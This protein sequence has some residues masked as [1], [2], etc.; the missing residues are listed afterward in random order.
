MF[1]GYSVFGFFI[2]V[3]WFKVSILV[4]HCV[5]FGLFFYFGFTFR[6]YDVFLFRVYVYGFLYFLHFNFGFTV[7]SFDFWVLFYSVWFRV[8]GLGYFCILDLSLGF[9][10]FQ[11]LWFMFSD[12][13]VFGFFILVLQFRV[14][15]LGIHC[16]GF[17][18]VFWVQAIFVLWIYVDGLRCF[19]IQGLCFTIIVFLAF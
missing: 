4:L 3:L 9:R 18:L 8:Q 13:C 2:F 6:V 7:Q 14:S 5:G 19:R 15:V 17:G 16:L 10:A 12:Y 11:S 1:Q